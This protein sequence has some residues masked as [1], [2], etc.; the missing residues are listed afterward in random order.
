MSN[1]PPGQQLAA[2]AKWPLV[3]ER[4]PA[5]CLGP[6]TVEITGQC[7]RPIRWTIEELLAIGQTEQVVDVHCVSR[8]SKPAMRFAGVPLIRLL[9]PAGVLPTARFISFV[10]HTERGHDTSLVLADAIEL[11]TLVA[12]TAEGRPLAPEHGGPVRIV[13]PGRYFYKSLKW[14]ARIELLASDRL[15]YWESQAGYHNFADPWREQRFIAPGLTRQ[16]MRAALATRDLSGCDLRSLDAAGHDLARLKAVGAILRDAT[17]DDCVLTGAD[18]SGANL[19]LARLRGADLR[20]AMFTGAD[21]EGAN[22]AGAD[23]RGADFRGAALTAASFRDA[24]GRV[25]NIDASTLFDPSAADALTPDQIPCLAG[26]VEHRA[27]TP[28]NEP[29]APA[30]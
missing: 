20:G 1:L 13:V 6:W 24:E 30:P 15:G 22:F 21:V 18:F 12:L 10:A 8:W 7:A 25:A 16:E 14:L 28:A 4:A 23:L 26:R 29:Q 19:S 17:F 11:K 5:T 3:G 9:E 2:V 27:N